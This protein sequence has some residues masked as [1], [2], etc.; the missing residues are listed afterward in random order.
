MLDVASKM[1]W[2][3]SGLKTLGLILFYYVFSIGLTFYNKLLLTVRGR[4]A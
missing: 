3:R 4:V 2:I 1:S